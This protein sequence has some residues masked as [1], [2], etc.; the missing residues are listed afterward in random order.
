MTVPLGVSRRRPD[1]YST[2]SFERHKIHDGSTFIDI[3][4]FVSLTSEKKHTFGHG[5]L[6]RVDV[7]DKT[8]IPDLLQVSFFC[9]CSSHAY[10]HPF[11]PCDWVIKAVLRLID[12]ILVLTSDSEQKP[13]WLLPF[14]E[15]PH[16]A[17]Q[18]RQCRV[19]PQV[20]PHTVDPL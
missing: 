13:G 12:L 3:T 15:D 8:Y 16:A 2:F 10:C 11:R 9:R 5:S 18:R 6:A 17:A 4:D 14:D 19:K 20:F 1:G 7:S